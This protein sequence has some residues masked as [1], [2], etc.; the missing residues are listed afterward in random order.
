M[1]VEQITQ[2]E[3]LREMLV[4]SLIDQEIMRRHISFLQEN[5][6][7]IQELS[8]SKH[9]EQLQKLKQSQ[10]RAEIMQKEQEKVLVEFKHDKKLLQL[11]R[12]KIENYQKMLDEQ[13]EGEELKRYFR[14]Q[15]ILEQKLTVTERKLNL[16][17]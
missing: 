1:Q 11:Q 10:I 8:R 5:T 13:I 6:S 4:Q 3:Q 15:I 14:S 7:K 9:H 16:Q 2:K 12:K 17:K